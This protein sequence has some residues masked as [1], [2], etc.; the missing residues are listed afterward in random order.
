MATAQEHECFA[1]L[2]DAYSRA[3]SAAKELSV[4]RPDQSRGWERIAELAAQLKEQCFQ[5]AEK[6]LH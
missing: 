2:I 6:G 3:E 1:K 4:L 5:F